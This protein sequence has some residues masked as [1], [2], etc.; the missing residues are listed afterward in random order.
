MPAAT[1]SSMKPYFFITRSSPDRVRVNMRGVWDEVT[2]TTIWSIYT[3]NFN[4]MSARFGRIANVAR[5]FEFFKVHKA[6]LHYVGSCA[7]SETGQVL[8][9][10]DADPA[11]EPPSS[12]PEFLNSGYSDMCAPYSSTSC[13][14]KGSDL[15]REWYPCQPWTVGRSGEPATTSTDRMNRPFQMQLATTGG[16]STVTGATYLDLDVEFKTPSEPNVGSQAVGTLGPS[17]L[18]ALGT[19]WI[20]FKSVGPIDWQ[21]A[22]LGNRLYLNIRSPGV[23]KASVS[24]SGSS[25][26]PSPSLTATRVTNSTL[27][28]A[29]GSTNYNLTWTTTLDDGK[30][31]GYATIDIGGT[32]SITALSALAVEF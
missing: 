21:L 12:I 17:T 32:G 20:H 28:A 24:F 31:N 7:T 27:V 25:L 26:A 23:F 15:L 22:A 3:L 10:V 29:G 13:E 8:L 19:S 14:I 2:M 16:N 30:D 5:S 18:P 6:K 1:Q 4:P 9:R 11:D